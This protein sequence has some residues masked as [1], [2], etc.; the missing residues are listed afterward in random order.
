MSY[1]IF[2]GE[3]IKTIHELSQKGSHNVRTKDNYKSNPNIRIEDSK[4][5][6]EIVEC[7]DYVKKFYEITK[8][9]QKEHSERMKNM[10]ADRKKSFL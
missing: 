8:E 1:A 3:G 4:N 10:R 5:N 6:I 9:Y 7:N 2:R